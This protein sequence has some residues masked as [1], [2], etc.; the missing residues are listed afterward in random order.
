M[1]YH[2]EAER[3]GWVFDGDGYHNPATDEWFET[4]EEALRKGFAT[5]VDQLTQS[6]ELPS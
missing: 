6:G 4:A 5:P 3:K 1:T 2:E